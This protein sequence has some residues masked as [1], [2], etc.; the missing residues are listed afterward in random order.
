MKKIICL[1]ILVA[2]FSCNSHKVFYAYEDNKTNTYAVLELSNKHYNVKYKYAS[3][4]FDYKYLEISGIKSYIDDIGV[5]SFLELSVIDNNNNLDGC[6]D[7]DT[8]KSFI[9]SLDKPEHNKIIL[10][11]KGAV[12][13]LDKFNLTWFP[14]YMTKVKKIDYSKFPED[15]REAVIAI[16]KGKSAKKVDAILAK[17]KK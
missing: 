9:Y 2:L 13:C 6:V 4:N 10:E 7:L 11:S 5:P 15:I 3:D 12:N 8:P 16:D 14:P 17:A 1:F